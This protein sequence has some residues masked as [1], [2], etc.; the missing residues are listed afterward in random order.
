ML[1]LVNPLPYLVL[2]AGL[3][4]FLIPALVIRR[5]SWYGTYAVLSSVAAVGAW[6][7]SDANSFAIKFFGVATFAGVFVGFVIHFVRRQI[8]GQDILRQ[9]MALLFVRLLIGA[10]PLGFEHQKETT[11]V[12]LLPADVEVSRVAYVHRG[13]TKEC[14]ISAWEVDWPQATWTQLRDRLPSDVSQRAR[15]G[16]LVYGP[17]KSTPYPVSQNPLDAKDRWLNGI[18]CSGVA[19]AIREQI[20]NA[21]T[22]AGSM[23]ATAGNTGVIVVPTSRLVVLSYSR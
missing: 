16:D 14:E 5:W 1:N 4:A 15:H 19:P 22:S 6:Y 8:A 18:G 11:N 12:G 17:W 20:V 2:F 9:P 21:L 23:Y 10:V 7:F 13:L 3:I